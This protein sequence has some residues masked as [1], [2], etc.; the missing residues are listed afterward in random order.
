MKKI[1][2]HKALKIAMEILKHA[3]KERIQSADVES[4]CGVNYNEIGRKK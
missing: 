3:E 1:T 2:R 4:K